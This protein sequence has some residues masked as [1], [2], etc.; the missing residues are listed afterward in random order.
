MYKKLCIFLLLLLL[1]GCKFKSA[2]TETIIKNDENVKIAI[3]YPV[4]KI[5]KIDKQVKNYVDNIYDV[6]KKDYSSAYDSE[7]NISYSYDNLNNYISISLTTFISVNAYAHPLNEI[8]TIVYDKKKNKILNLGDVLSKEK[9]KEETPK[10]KKQL[11]NKYKECIDIS[12]IDSKINE[13]LINYD[14]FL[15]NE[16]NIMILF[17]PYD[18]TSGNCNIINITIPL[19]NSTKK[20]EDVVLNITPDV[21]EIDSSKPTIALTFDDG[22]SKYTK[23]IVELLKKYDAV[24][25]FFIIGNKVEIYD[26][27]IKLMYQNGNEIG[28]HSYDHKWLT[29]LTDDELNEQIEKTNEII[30]KTTGVAPLLLR[31]SYG[32]INKKLREN[33][34]LDIVMWDVDT[35][36]WE[37]K[38]Y[39]KIA[40]KA[41]SKIKDGDIILMH[42]VY[43]R[44]YKALEIMLPKLK[45]QGFQLVTVS[46]L[47]E[48]KKLKDESN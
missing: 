33:I 19:N 5:K 34:K 31:P 6:F 8:Y 22:P 43:E 28:N 37:I 7:L 25:T 35:R 38:N 23:K 3:N 14:L 40:D 18:V 10:L 26:E 45:E 9:L 48:L 32:A 4:T 39:K 15:I 11:I 30:K 47:N 29:R 42:D 21:I 41:L 16:D 36:D 2:K 20:S 17:N 12:L 13:D 24:G 27:T 1:T 46:T 44:T